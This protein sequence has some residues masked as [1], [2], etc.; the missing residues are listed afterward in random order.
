MGNS[1]LSKQP[2]SQAAAGAGHKLSITRR[3]DFFGATAAIHVVYLP[4]VR[5]G[6]GR[7]IKQDVDVYSVARIKDNAW[8]GLV[9]RWQSQGF[10][11][12]GRQSHGAVNGFGQ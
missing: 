4:G 10:V 11:G 2:R 3:D 8:A 9:D 5:Q 1:G 7:D 12:T 6:I